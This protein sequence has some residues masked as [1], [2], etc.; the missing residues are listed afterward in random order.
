[1]RICVIVPT[2]NE[3][4]NVTKLVYK[5]KQTKIK[6]DILFIDDD[7]TDGTQSEIKLIKKRFLNIKY[8]FR[9]KKLGIGSAHKD[10]IRY[11][12]KNNYDLIIT[13]DCDGTHDPKYFRELIKKSKDYDY[14]ITSRFKK[15]GLIEDWP[16][17][18]KIITYTRHLMVMVFLGIRLD[19]SG[20]FRCFYK[21]KIK[22]KDLLSAHNNDYAY[23]WEI[24]YNLLRKSYSIYEVP[25][26]LEF[27]KLGKSKMKL[28][29]IVYSLLYLIRIFLLRF[30]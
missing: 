1:M 26:K 19:A 4:E 8:I 6:L 18:R 15:N 14:V 2:L 30:K 13:M 20:A 23:F 17:T 5:I 7:S 21:K 3:K 12:Y 27:R 16:I 28:K 11:C 25:V 24:S 9:K 22:L 10:G 29:H